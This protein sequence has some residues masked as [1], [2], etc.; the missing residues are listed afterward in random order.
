MWN[1]L[2]FIFKPRQSELFPIEKRSLEKH[3]LPGSATAMPI[4]QNGYGVS[5]RENQT[6]EK[7]GGKKKSKTSKGNAA[8]LITAA[9]TCHLVNL[10]QPE[11]GVDVLAHLDSGMDNV[12][13]LYRAMS[14]LIHT[15]VIENPRF[16]HTS[17]LT[18]RLADL[19]AVERTFLTLH[20][21]GCRPEVRQGLPAIGYAGVK[22]EGGLAQFSFSS[23]TAFTR[24]PRICKERSFTYMRKAAER[25]ALLFDNDEKFHDKEPSFEI[26]PGIPA[27]TFNSG[28]Q[29]GHRGEYGLNIPLDFKFDQA[30]VPI[31]PAVEMK[32][33]K[34]EGGNYIQLHAKEDDGPLKAST[35]EEVQKA[36]YA[37]ARQIVRSRQQMP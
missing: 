8:H 1:L 12:T 4:T 22:K 31:S 18:H 19:N 3:D 13:S 25:R 35:I 10:S 26:Y 5:V 23:V 16:A 2:K 21:L 17:I 27:L 9:S 14:H 34:A 11:S 20:A 37:I 28:E 30:A 7:N 24:V 32:I 6:K 33:R 15:G 36:F 29:K